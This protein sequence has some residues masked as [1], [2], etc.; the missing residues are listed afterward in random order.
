MRRLRILSLNTLYNA[1]PRVRLRALADELA[2]SDYDVVCL[3]ELWIPQNF[4]LF[5]SL[6]KD[7]YPHVAHGLRL[8]VVAGGLLTMSRIPIV[9]HR[10]EMVAQKRAWRR[11]TL[12]RK[13]VL[14]ARLAVDGQFLTVANTHLSANMHADWSRAAPFTKVQQRELATL[15]ASLRRIDSGEPVVAVGDF[16]VPRDSWLFEGFLAASGLRDVFD[17]DA[18]TTF[19]PVPGWDGAAL[20]QVVVSPGLAAAAE[21]V[22][23]DKVRTADGRDRY[24]SDHFGVA[25]TIG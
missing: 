6:T 13:G 10:Y 17:G 16:N 11:E 23:R 19:R 4:Q 14:I 12:L 15:A 18:A 21:V 2:A 24:L 5:R 1:A 8:P 9:G 22:L 3:Q 20:D 7:S 25:A